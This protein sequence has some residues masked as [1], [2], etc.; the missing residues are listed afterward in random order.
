MRNAELFAFMFRECPCGDDLTDLRKYGQGGI[1]YVGVGIFQ[2]CFNEKSS[3]RGVGSPSEA[4]H[5][6]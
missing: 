3:D 6:L 1:P 4:E 5:H 2:G